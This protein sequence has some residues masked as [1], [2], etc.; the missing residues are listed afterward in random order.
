MNKTWSLC[1]VVFEDDCIVGKCDPLLF[2][3]WRGTDN[4]GDPLTSYYESFLSFGKF[5]KRDVFLEMI[6]M[7]EDK[8]YLTYNDN[9]VLIS[10][11]INLPKDI[12][13]R[14][15]HIEKSKR[16]SKKKRRK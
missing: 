12:E 2:I 10:K 7:T 14:L 8:E 1:E 9:G 15:K 13:L 6:K 16:K 5:N 3:T 11:E 4:F